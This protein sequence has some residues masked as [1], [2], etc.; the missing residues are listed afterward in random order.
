MY[1]FQRVKFLASE[2]AEP[3]IR[4]LNSAAIFVTVACRENSHWYVP[5]AEGKAFGNLL[6]E[7]YCFDRPT[8]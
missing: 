5:A 8:F 4:Q 6:A 7:D 2:K 3:N 1:C